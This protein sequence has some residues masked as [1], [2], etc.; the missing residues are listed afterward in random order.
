MT[1]APR[2]RE[3]V[4]GSMMV[5]MD[6]TAGQRRWRGRTLR[7]GAPATRLASLLALLLVLGLAGCAGAAP[8]SQS[9]EATAQGA[10]RV[11]EVH[12][13]PSC[14]CCT[15]YVAYL[16]RH[17]WTVEV[18]EEPDIG[19]FQDERGV[20]EDARGCHTMLIGGYLVDGHVPLPAIERLLEERPA[21]D[22]IGLPGMPMG[23]PGMTGTAAGPLA[24]VA[25]AGDQ[26]TPFGEY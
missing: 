18:V 2:L 16:R 23:S 21:V 14:G 13:S 4:R 6:E 10:A 3:R 20:P 9:A 12:L 1:G 26:V 22:G 11:A 15:E 24:V 25:Y 7:V 17:G 8:R 5:P 19:A